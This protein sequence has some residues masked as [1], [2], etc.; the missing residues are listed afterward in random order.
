MKTLNWI[1]IMIV[2]LVVSIIIFLIFFRTNMATLKLYRSTS[3]VLPDSVEEAGIVVDQDGKISKILTKPDLDTMDPNSFEV[4]DFG[5]L[6]IMP[7]V[8]DSH[9][10]VNEPGRT[11][12]EGYTTAT[13]A[14]AKGGVTTIIDMPLNSIPPTTTIEN[15]NTKLKAAEG[16]NYVDLGFWG[17]VIPGNQNELVKLVEAGVVGFKCFLCPS[18]V[19]EF[20]NVNQ[21]D[22]QLALQALEGTNS[23]LAFHAELELNNTTP[24]GDPTIYETF[25]ESRPDEMEV[26]AIKI[27]T[28]LCAKHSVRCHI[29]H[30]AAAKALPILRKFRAKNKNLTVETCHHY[31]TFSSEEIPQGKTQYKCC[32]PIRDHENRELLWAALQNHDIDQVVSDHSPCTPN[33]KFLN[34]TEKPADFMKAWG[35]I[36]SVQ[37]G[38]SLFWTEARKRG[39]NLLDVSHFLCK[40]PSKLIGLESKKGQLKEGLDADFVVWNQNETFVVK[41]SDIEMKNKITP[42]LNMEFYGKVYK[43]FVRGL[44]V[45]DKD[46]GFSETPL[47]KLNIKK[48]VKN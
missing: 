40:G 26:E 6:V 2:P 29:V 24:I 3:V 14:A 30:L 17:G 16:K 28:E 32:P 36:A 27:V 42:Y 9:V 10:H 38:L 19:D 21:E 35:G 23:V 12:W 15:F 4:I 8:V 1:F 18:G 31:L 46:E 7:G 48:G 5:D 43:T 11:D 25:L 22:I 47:G 34:N 33:L 37:F 44:K 41:Q 39:L 45:Y 20:P 13:R